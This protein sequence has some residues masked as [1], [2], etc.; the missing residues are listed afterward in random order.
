MDEANTSWLAPYA[1]NLAQDPKDAAGYL[2][3]ALN[4]R[5]NQ[6]DKLLADLGALAIDDRVEA[7]EFAFPSQSAL[8]SLLMYLGVPIPSHNGEA[9]GDG[10]G[11]AP[12]LAGSR[13]RLPSRFGLHEPGGVARPP[14]A[15]PWK[16]PSRPG[17]AAAQSNTSS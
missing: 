5:V 3:G 6:T 13:R 10:H 12:G 4:R 7:I 2:K 15:C 1:L 8:R 9:G 17:G 11:W 14:A 16:R